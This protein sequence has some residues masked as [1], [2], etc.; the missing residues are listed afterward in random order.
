MAARSRPRAGQL[1]D[2]LDEERSLWSQ[3]QEDAKRIDILMV[4]SFSHPALFQYTSTMSVYRAGSWKYA[5]TDEI[6]EETEFAK[7]STGEFIRFPRMGQ[8][9][10]SHS[11]RQCLALWRQI[12]EYSSRLQRTMVWHGMAWPAS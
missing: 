11:N 6:T 4:R 5:S 8:Q 1:K 12:K 2:E 7:I 9:S 10:V 3:I